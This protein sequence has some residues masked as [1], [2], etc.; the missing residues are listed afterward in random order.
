[1]GKDLIWLI[2]ER[3]SSSRID[4]GEDEEVGNV[5]KFMWGLLKDCLPPEPK[6]L[7]SP[8]PE[9]HKTGLSK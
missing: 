1:M 7:T 8:S 9:H 3:L 4:K 2:G 5:E 6:Q